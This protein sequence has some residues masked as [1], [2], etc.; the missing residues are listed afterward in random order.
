MRLT[1]L[2]GAILVAPILL[3][4]QTPARRTIDFTTREGTWMSPDV[5]RDGR[6]I[7]FD[8]V[9]E[10]YTLP[11]E[12]G[13]A[14]PIITGGD[15]AS[16]PRFSPDG[17]SILFVS[18]RDGSDNLW[19]SAAD[20]SAQRQITHLPRSILI[21]PLWSA[22]GKTA[23][24]TVI[25]G[26]FPFIA[27]VWEFDLGTGAGV[28]LIENANGPTSQL[29]SEPAPGPYGGAVSADGRYVYYASVTPRAYGVRNGTSS[30]LMRFDRTTK[31]SEPVVS[32]GTNAMRPLL[33]PDGSLLVYGA[34]SGGRSGLR[35]RRLSDGVER[36]LRLPV[37][38][39][40]LESRATRDML[41]GYAFTSDGKTLIA[42]Y[43]GGLH[44]IDIAT[45]RESSIPF[46]AH[47]RLDVQAP[48]HTPQTIGDGPVV[49]RAIQYP[50]QSSDGRITFSAMT[51]VYVTDRT[52]VAPRRLT[53]AVNPRE[54]WPSFSRDG[55][56]IAFVTWTS[57]AGHLWTVRA[58]GS[59]PPTR[60]TSASAFYAEPTWSPDGARIVMLRAPA[61]SARHQPQAIPSDAELVSIPAV[62]GTVTR[63]TS[64]AGLRRPHFGRAADRVYASSSA[65]L[66]SMRLDGSDRRLDAAPMRKGPGIRMLVSPDGSAVA[67]QV[68]NTLLRL[69][70]D[71]RRDTTPASLDAAAPGVET[72]AT[73]A[74][75]FFSW[76]ADGGTVNWVTGRVVHR[77]RRGTASDT[78]S[79]IDSIAIAVEVPRATPSGSIV[80]HDVRAITMRGDEVIPHADILITRNRIAAIGPAGSLAIPAGVQSRDMGGRTV[81]PGLID[82][83]AHWLVPQ[84]MVRPDVTAPLANLA[85]GVTTVRDPQSFAEIFT[86][87]DL[88]DAGEMPSPRI[89]STGPG[90]FADLNFASLDQARETLRRYKTRYGTHLL[91]SYY[92]GNRQQ[93]QWVVQAASE[94]GMMPTTEGAS[95]SRVDM[96]HAMDGY[97]GNEHSLPDSPLYRDVIQLLAQSGITYTPTL[98]VAFGGSFPIYRLMAEENPSADPVLRH[99]FPAEELY[100]RSATRLLWS[101]PED[102]RSVDQARDVTAILRAGGQVA[103]GGHGEMQ[104]LQNHWEMRLMT[105][106]GMTPHEALRVATINGATALGLEREIGSLEVG[107]LADLVILDQ[108]PLKD[109]RATTSI[110]AVMR[111]G[112]LYDA[113][114]LNRVWPDSLALPPTWWQR[115][116]DSTLAATRTFDGA[117]VD[118]AVTAQ[119]TSQKIPGVGLAVMQRGKV[120][121]S[122]GYGFANLEHQVR[123]TDETM[124]ESGSLGKQFTSAGILALVEDGKLRLDES[125]RTFL[126]DA[127]DTW[128]P[129][130]IRHLL[131]HTSG[132]PDYTGD[133]MDYR[134]DYTEAE[135]LKLA[136]SL[137]LEFQAGA[138]WNYSNTGYVVLG[139]L[140]SKLSGTPYWEYLRQRIFTPAG[141]PTIRIITESDIVPHRS[142]GYLP[143][144]SG[145]R[146][147][148]WV[149]PRLNTTAD[150]SMLLSVR[151]LVA[152]GET[153]RTR[154]VL[155]PESWAQILT[156]VTLRSGKP[157]PYGFG[158][159]I[160]SLRGHVVYQ[161][162]GSWQGFRTQIYRYESADL[163]VAVLTNSG[164]ANPAIIATDVATA[165]DSSLAPAT[166]PTV[167]LRDAD[168]AVTVKV[169]EVLVRAAQNK[170]TTADFSFFRQTTF[171]RMQAF[172]ARTLQGTTAPDRLEL[173]LRRP[174]GDD[175]EYVY[176]ARYGT[177]TFRVVVS[178]APDGGLTGLIARPEL[179]TGGR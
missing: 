24:V 124:F 76:S 92:L 43:G 7:V 102:A 88:A 157:H 151:D 77:A 120:L 87:A 80:L 18:D 83:H 105:A 39:N 71:A 66:I 129:I 122:K 47:V 101:R 16:Q 30:R 85:Y 137:P 134:K 161:H 132:V 98:L 58:D 52:G 37:D 143:T 95:D 51:R 167:P 140:I 60:V 99:W 75:E 115:V 33:S 163:T 41:P 119:M 82:I 32:E 104:G 130:T 22:D 103:L 171:P 141:M 56:W 168:A 89:Y 106:G 135:L 40:A 133:K 59:A 149:A 158:W 153:V 26:Y 72:L 21:S 177:R 1:Q 169:R 152:W 11:R 63:I 145:W 73:D 42:S 55:R 123:T 128:Q 65:G 114:T 6:T 23:L 54:Y 172:M 139:A 27:D 78:K 136:Y 81:I 131:S 50:Q 61:G 46:E 156:P 90:L 146:H 17:Q 160:D 5:S 121:V 31:Q 155:T 162:G 57:D 176:L 164:A 10:L 100:Q 74:P 117:A 68:G 70:L 173:Y 64:A 118:A 125:I 79:V 3:A 174:V 159:F 126:P 19:T 86:F 96:T 12:G 48:L 142:S 69:P 165:I 38:R 53:R 110:R 28:K 36:W 49:A 112:F 44:A 170:L 13:T 29:V 94:L 62:G 9:G 127:P 175:T 93:R 107:K 113:S 4:A 166:L 84:D 34:E 116:T 108:D 20:G 67:M 25:T 14:T 15:F 138:R 154:A 150:G 148:D 8:V 147:Q 178:L 45:G 2:C 109:I 144:D 97:S 179:P 111:N 91:K 35:V